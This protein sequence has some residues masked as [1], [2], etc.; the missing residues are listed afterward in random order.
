M[1]GPCPPFQTLPAGLCSH[2]LSSLR[3]SKGPCLLPIALFLLVASLSGMLRLRCLASL[4]VVTLL[5]LDIQDGMNSGKI[6]LTPRFAQ[7]SY[8]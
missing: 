4:V 3:S 6:S 2:T 7:G 5:T 8:R 1:V